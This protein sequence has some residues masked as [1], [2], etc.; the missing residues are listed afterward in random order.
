[1]KVLVDVNIFIDVFTKRANWEGSLR[2]LNLVRRAPE[3]EGWISALT[4]PLLYFYRLRVVAEQQ[5]RTD[6]QAA[7]KGFQFVP[8]TQALLDKAL[9]SALP[10]FEDNIQ[11]VSAE[12]IAADYVV[13]RNKKHFQPA[14]LPILA[15]EEWLALDAVAQIKTEPPTGD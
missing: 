4:V 11:L 9:S 6:T 10:D 15:P 1:M 5:A 13:T 14:S 3:V 7:V 8:L 2:V 12:T